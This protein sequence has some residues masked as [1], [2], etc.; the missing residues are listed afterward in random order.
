MTLKFQ[1]KPYTKVPQRLVSKPRLTVEDMFKKSTKNSR[2]KAK[3]VRI[4]SMQKMRTPKILKDW[5]TY[6]LMTQNMEN[7]HRY[8]ITI[9]SPT[10]LIK[11]KTKVIIDSPNANFVYR[12]EYAL[13][14]R[15]NAF[16]YRS[17]GDAR[18]SRLLA[19]NQTSIKLSLIF[20]KIQNK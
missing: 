3:K 7:G 20:I 13:A 6:R 14:K 10:L 4:L 9:F 16:I 18:P 1:I 12:Y 11:P 17:N 5:F 8:K 19:Q 15:G 2:D